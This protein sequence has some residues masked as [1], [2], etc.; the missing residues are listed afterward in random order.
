MKMKQLLFSMLTLLC[1]CM[2]AWAQSSDVLSGV[3]TI[4]AS[5]D[6]VHFSKGNLQKVDGNYQFA[7]HQY[8]Y[9]GT[10]QSANHCDL[11]AFNNYQTPDG[12]VLWRILSKDEWE[13][14][15]T[16]RS[17]NNT[18]STDARYSKATIGDE[19]KGVIVFPDNYTHPEG[20]GFSGSCN[21]AT[22]IFWK[23]FGH[24]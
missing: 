1:C 4:N 12:D 18:L 21:N 17:V 24:L 22:Q 14:L 20:T 16:K 15:L 7:E 2:G 23:L 3:F 9:F 5:G 11:F 13:Y 10:T 8:E 19:Y 6:K